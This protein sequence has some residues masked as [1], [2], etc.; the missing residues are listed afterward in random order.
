[1]AFDEIGQVSWRLVGYVQGM[2][3]ETAFG[4]DL[5]EIKSSNWLNVKKAQNV[6]A[7]RYIEDISLIS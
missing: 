2:V 4:Y 3:L 6:S 5:A 1:M 7:Q